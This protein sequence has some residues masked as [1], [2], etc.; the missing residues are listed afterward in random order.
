LIA[1]GLIPTTAIAERLLRD[2]YGDIE[3]VVAQGLSGVSLGGRQVFVSR[4][5]HPRFDWFVDYFARNRI[6]Y[7]YLLDDN[8][9]EL[10]AEYDAFNASFFAH[11]AVHK[12][13]ERFLLSAN[14]VWVMS[15]PLERYLQARL[16][17]IKTR[18][19]EAPVDIELFDR[20]ARTTNDKRKD[21]DAFVVGYPTTRRPNVAGLVSDVVRR[22]S[23]LWGS[24]IKFEFIG[25]CPEEITN[26]PCVEVFP[27]VADYESYLRLMFSRRWDAAIAPLGNSAFEN[28]KT[29]L[30]FREYG[31][32]RIP[33]VYSDC[34]L[35]ASCI[36]AG[37]NGLLARDIPEDWIA[38]LGLLK[39]SEALRGEIVSVARGH[40]EAR[41]AQS[42]IAGE[43]RG[44]FSN[45]WGLPL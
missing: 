28:A 38:K 5:C 29:S 30:K 8:F 12:T 36:D 15:R 16:P 25:W 34:P 35:F 18:F 24:E 23:E 2:A 31:A 1:D 40:V 6:P 33:G 44:A 42:R 7:V 32:A 10:T 19:L 20:C 37:V 22:S 3:V 17:S 27:L 26:H 41:H 14:A 11:P 4:V 43:L 9:F 13:L 45:I 21:H 39:N